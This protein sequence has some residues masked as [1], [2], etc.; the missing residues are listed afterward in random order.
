[1][2]PVV[3]LTGGLATRM[4][5]LTEKVPKAMLDIDGRPFIYHQLNLLKKK[6]IN[7]VILCVGFLGEKIENYVGD[8]AKFQ[9]DVKYSYD[10]EKLLGTGGAIKKALKYLDDSFFVLYG[11]S[12]LDV[13]YE[14]IETT[15]F[16]APAKGL[17]TVYKNE[18]KWDT[19]NVVYRNNEI[20]MYS[21][22]KQTEEM[23]YID[24]G[25]G[26]L[27][28]SVFHDFKNENAF[29][30]ACVYEKLA[31][32]KQLMGYEVFE[33]FYEIGSKEGLKEL[34]Q[35]IYEQGSIYR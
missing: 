5:P 27:S 31:E 1:M 30:L 4:K 20:L 25:L 22:K 10:G 16:K 8:G 7:R 32:E 26:V 34:K 29:D 19:S 33:R 35:K 23:N 28:K 18:G 15:F 9:L 24:Y 11:D 6:G 3:I 14:E 17:M 13:D 12:Y 21:K 2:F